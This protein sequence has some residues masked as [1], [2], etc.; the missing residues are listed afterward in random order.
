MATCQNCHTRET[1]DQTGYC[2]KTKACAAARSKE[3]RKRAKN[4]L[5]RLRL[6]AEK[7]NG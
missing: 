3:Q 2:R 1:T 5:E 4:E 6:L 7:V